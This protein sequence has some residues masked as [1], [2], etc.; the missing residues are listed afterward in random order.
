MS[1]E[2]PKFPFDEHAEVGE[3]HVW[4][5]HGP[6][7]VGQPDGDGE[8]SASLLWVSRSGGPDRVCPPG[9]HGTPISEGE[10]TRVLPI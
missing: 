3:Q 5:R 7:S 4:D 1:A 9:G 8:A 10:P 6:H 2:P